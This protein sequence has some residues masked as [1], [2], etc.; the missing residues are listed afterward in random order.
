VLSYACIV[1]KPYVVVSCVHNYIVAKLQAYVILLC[2]AC[3]AAK[4]YVIHYQQMTMLF[5]YFIRTDRI[6]HNFCVEV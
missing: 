4:S 2:D 5:V 6:I 3:I 1:A